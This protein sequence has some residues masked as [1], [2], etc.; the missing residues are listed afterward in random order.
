MLQEHSHDLNKK[1]VHQK[2]RDASSL[3]FNVIWQTKKQFKE[4]DV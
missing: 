3:S 4:R 2:T 1:K